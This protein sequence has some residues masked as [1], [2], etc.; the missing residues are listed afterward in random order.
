MADGLAEPLAFR[1]FLAG[2]WRDLTFE[3]FRE[4]VEISVLMAGAPTV[5]VLRYAPG[6]SV[7]RHV[8]AGLETVLVLEGS[9]RDE[10][11]VY[12]AGALVLNTTASEHDVRSDDGCVVLIQWAEPV[13]FVSAEERQP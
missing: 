10:R 7:P 6:A 13:Q 5:A 9:Q 1:D 2:G 11:G 12:G 3:P 4:G 8:H